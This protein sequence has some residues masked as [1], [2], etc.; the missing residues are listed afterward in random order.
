MPSLERPLMFS[1]TFAEMSGS[2]PRVGS[3]SM[4]TFGLLRSAFARST[5]AFCP[6]ESLPNSVFRKGLIPKRSITSSIFLGL[7]KICA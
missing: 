4:R 2:S 1:R 7:E 3:S 5:R 6:V